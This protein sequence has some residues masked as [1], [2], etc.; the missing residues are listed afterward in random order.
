MISFV[1]LAQ[2]NL[3]KLEKALR[4]TGFQEQCTQV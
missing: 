4:Q 1:K 3:L 2:P